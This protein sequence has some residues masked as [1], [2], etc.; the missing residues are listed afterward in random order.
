VSGTLR[1][2]LIAS[3]LL[4][5]AASS[6]AQSGTT[7]EAASAAASTPSNDAVKKRLD[8]TDFQS[9]FETRV[10]H[11]N[12]RDGASRNLI[13]PRLEYAF[14]KTLA[15][16]VET[17]YV[18]SHPDGTDSDRGLGD[19]VVRL[20]YRALR[21]EG[22]AVVLGPEL[23]LDTAD[24]GLGFNATVF[25]PV[26]FVAID[27]PKYKAVL[28][29]YAQQFVDIA[30]E[31]DVNVTLLRMG[32]LKRLPN[33]FYSFFEPSYYIDWERDG[34]TGTTFEL[35]VGRVMT[36]KLAIWA[37]PGVGTGSNRL[38]YVYDWNFE[39]GFR[40]FLD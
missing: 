13:V 2:A 25:Q 35:E 4:L 24:E 7:S 15:L 16:R 34:R 30:G 9:R 32:L 8:P 39:V 6:L 11:Q 31:N 12:L 23:A 1:A 38:P 14:S 20:N 3:S 21:G 10:E 33:R 29:P 18:W 19:I 5:C 22:Y 26:A 36:N 27:L 17:P 40:Y 37:R 28:F